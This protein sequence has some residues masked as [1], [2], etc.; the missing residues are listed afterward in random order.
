M[1]LQLGRFDA[2]REAYE[3]NLRREPRRARSLY[4]AARAAELAGDPATARARY[5]ELLDVMAKADASRR[6]PVAARAF[7]AQRAAH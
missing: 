1:L 3:A 5:T 6:E 7:L 2:A 4:G